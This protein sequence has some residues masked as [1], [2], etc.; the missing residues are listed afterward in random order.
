MKDI[1]FRIPKHE[2][3]YRPKPCIENKNGTAE[4]SAFMVIPQQ[5]IQMGKSLPE[6]EIT[7]AVTFIT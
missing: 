1:S 7:A 3:L 4:Y 6:I 2:L 5:A